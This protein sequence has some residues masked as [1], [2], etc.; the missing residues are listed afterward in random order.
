MRAILKFF[1]ILFLSRKSIRDLADA[2]HLVSPGAQHGGEGD[3]VALLQGVDLA[4]DLVGPAV[5]VE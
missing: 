5:V 2:H 3:G 1:L 4:E